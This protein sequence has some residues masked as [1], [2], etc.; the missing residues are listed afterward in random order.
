MA[1]STLAHQQLTGYERLLIGGEWVEPSSD[2]KIDVIS[3]FTEEVIARVPHAQPPDVDRAVAAARQAFDDGPWP[4]LPPAERAQYL[5]KLRDEIELRLDDMVA[6]FTADVGAPTALSVAFHQM[7]LA[8]LADAATLHERVAFEEERDWDGVR[9]ARL[10]REPIGVVAAITPWNGPVGVACLKMGPALA[11]GCTFILKP[12][13]EGLT[14]VMLLADAIAATGFP[15]GV[16]SILPAGRAV[17]EYLV[18]HP[19][20]DKITFTGSTAAGRRIMSLCAERIRP[21]TLELGGKSAA[22]I[23]DD[24]PLEEVLPSLVPA[25]VGHSGQVCAALTRILVPR[26]RQEE[27]IEGLR[28]ALAAWK[29]GDPTDPD[30]VLG[31]LVA[32]RQRRRV[33]DYIKLGQEEGA[34]LAVGGGRPKGL[35]HGWFVE[36]TVFADVDNNM[37]IAQEEIFGPV[38]TVI[39][40]DDVEEAV[41]IANDTQ[42]GLSGAV[43]AR[44]QKL[45]EDIARRIRTGQVGVNSW[46]M[47][48][49]QPFGGYKQSGLGRE[50]GVEGIMPYLETKLLM[51]NT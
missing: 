49:V 7:P 45:A 15:P 21:V 47:C 50:G 5:L 16:V 51:S 4:K 8:M 27:L 20:I 26:E 42:Y 29:P 38:L 48:I 35:E 6:A 31:P 33:E 28:R 11:A 1:T 37:R 39:P 22:I 24:V 2:K 44:D 41:E 36:P 13:E 23:A 9:R 32:E 3:P 14:S 17:G 34:R 18:T 40:F 43:Y 46:D 19:G 10:V 30:T 25:G 12:A